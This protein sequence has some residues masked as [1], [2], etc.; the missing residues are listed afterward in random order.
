MPFP[1]SGASHDVLPES[2]SVMES[3]SQ[4]QTLSG[5][6]VSIGIIQSSQ[7]PTIQRLFKG[8]W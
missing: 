7:F 4:A 5:D 8:I 1:M 2:K 6:V 3:S